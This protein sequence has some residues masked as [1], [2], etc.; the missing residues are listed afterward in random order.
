MLGP[1]EGRVV[2]SPVV[3][4][5]AMAMYGSIIRAR[6]ISYGSVMRGWTLDEIQDKAE[7]YSEETGDRVV[8][9]GVL[10]WFFL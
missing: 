9:I 5:D 1:A 8:Q 6:A 10:H 2:A 4:Y 3:A 7:A